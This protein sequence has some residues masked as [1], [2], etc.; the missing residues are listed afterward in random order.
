MNNA[1]IPSR[2]PTSDD[3][4]IGAL[5]IAFRKTLESTDGQLPC[6]IISYDRTTN[7]AL[8]Q[9][10]ISMV[11]TAGVP[12]V[13]GQIASVPVLSLGGGGFCI[14]FPLKKGDLGWIEAS[15]R[16]ISLFMQQLQQSRPNTFR[17]HDFSDGRFIPD[18][19]NQYTFN[20]GDA[21]NMVIQSYDGTVKI[22]LGPGLINVDAATV[23][24]N[25]TTTNINTTNMTVTGSGMATFD[26]ATTFNNPVT[27]TDGATINSIPFQTHTHPYNPGPGASTETGIPE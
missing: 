1:L 3:N 17:I 4:L 26:I 21:A 23:T 10:L 16:D 24:V 25:S 18:A 11:T 22:A 19:F 7:R 5:R 20:S 12:V 2:N 27:M 13:R 8:V 15:D 9:P 6:E 14:T